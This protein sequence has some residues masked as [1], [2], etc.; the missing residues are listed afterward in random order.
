VSANTCRFNPFVRRF[1]PNGVD[2]G[3]HYPDLAAK[4]SQPSV[5]FVGT[6]DGRKRGRLLLDW[7][8]GEVRRPYPGATLDMVCP[9]GPTLPGVTYHTGIGTTE[10]ATLYRRAWVYA[11]PSSYEG[12]GLPYVEAMASGTPVLATPNPG[13]CEVLDNGLQGV[14]ANDDAF[15]RELLRLLGDAALREEYAA[16]GLRRAGDFSISSMIDRYEALIEE[17][18]SRRRG[19]RGHGRRSA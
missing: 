8:E 9:P 13:S 2:L 5:L 7:F 17:E 19:R 3:E 10:L 12:F 4:T 11:S 16:H 15:P 18:F 6:L 14:L 1:I